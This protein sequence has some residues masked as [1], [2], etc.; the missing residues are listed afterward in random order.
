MTA[1]CKTK[2]LHQLWSNDELNL[3]RKKSGQRQKQAKET[4]SP[5]VI[6]VTN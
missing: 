4:E 5:D 2:E 1:R 3:R 6:R